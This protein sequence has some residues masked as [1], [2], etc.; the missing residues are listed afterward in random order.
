ME[1]GTGM[2]IFFVVTSV[3]GVAMGLFFSVDSLSAKFYK[4]FEE[5]DR[6][7]KL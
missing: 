3:V 5:E 4:I 2:I 6:N 1:I 7:K